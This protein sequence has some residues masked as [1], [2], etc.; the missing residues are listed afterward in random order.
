MR[1]LTTATLAAAGAC[2]VLLT[3]LCGSALAAA[4]KRPQ[5]AVAEEG[6]EI[7]VEEEAWDE[8]YVGVEPGC[9][10]LEPCCGLPQGLLW[11]E[12]DYLLW[13][14]KG[15][16]IPP[17]V[18]SGTTGALGAPGTRILYGDETIF[19]DA[20]SGFR[21][22]LGSWFDCG[23]GYGLEGDYWM[24]GETT[25]HFRAASDSAGSPALFRPFFNVNPRGGDGGFDPPAREDAEI[26]SSPG[27]LAGAVDVDSYSQ[28]QGAGLRFRRQLCCATSCSGGCDPCCQPVETSSRLDLLVGYRYV[29]LREGIAIREDLT[30]LLSAPEQ[31]SFDILD[32]FGTSNRFHGADLGV[33]WRGRCG[34]WLV[35]VLGKLAL[36]G[37]QQTVTIDGQTVISESLNDNGTYAGGLLAQRT[38]MGQHRRNVF[39]MIPELGVNLGYQL[40]PCLSAKIGYNFLYW[41]RVVRPGD[42]IDLDV[43]PDLLP[44]ELEFA[45]PARPRFEW[46]DADYW[47]QGIRV[48]LEGVW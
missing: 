30:S 35:D 44:P 32:Q 25:D 4:E 37:V 5:A 10:V 46:R 28:L 24:L 12:A 9:R 2:L 17:L 47:A 43:N 19:D 7:I 3:S 20:R 40:T 21:V 26:V 34:P 48:G 22:G 36:G 39:A 27:V 41:S 45:G 38:N 14:T 31:G 15:M 33:T 18:T 23:R 1:K 11:C 8:D 16:E 6:E 13:W 29:Q 42:E